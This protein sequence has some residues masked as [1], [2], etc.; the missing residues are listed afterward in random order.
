MVGSPPTPGSPV[1][2][3][4]TSV[5]TVPSPRRPPG[6][7]PEFRGWYENDLGWPT[8]PGSPVRLI[9]GRDFDVLEVPRE[10]GLATLEH[11]TAGAAGRH[12]VQGGPASVGPVLVHG[13]RMGFLVAA[14]GAEEVPGILRWL[15]WGALPLDLVAVGA[16]GS[17]L[18]PLPPGALRRG[19]VQGA[20]V[21]LRPPVPGREESSLPT[22]SAPGVDE[23]AP[24]LVRLVDTLATHAHRVRLRSAS[25]QPLAF[26]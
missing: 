4:L 16:G 13:D 10:A 8:V 11:L 26:S 24:G 17:V 3:T 19:A 20:A 21:W 23:G 12:G 1:G 2:P 25:A 9:T 6:P 7:R 22:M 15:E 14:G 18:A 5:T